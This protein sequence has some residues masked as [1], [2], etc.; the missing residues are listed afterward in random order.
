MKKVIITENEIE[1]IGFDDV[2]F[3]NENIEGSCRDVARVGL[4]WALHKLVEDLEKDVHG[5]WPNQVTTVE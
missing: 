1:V 2:E 4:A 5:D 3:Q